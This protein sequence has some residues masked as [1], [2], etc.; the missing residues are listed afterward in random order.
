[1]NSGTFQGSDFQMTPA[2]N[3]TNKGVKIF[4]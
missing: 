3:I 4:R 1:V 2:K